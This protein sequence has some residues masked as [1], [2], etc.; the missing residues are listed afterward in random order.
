MTATVLLDN[1]WMLEVRDAP[2][3]VEEEEA[4]R[5]RG[6]SSHRPRIA[7]RPFNPLANLWGEARGEKSILQ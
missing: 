5:K 1:V 3:G 2:K 6:R 7:L 4:P